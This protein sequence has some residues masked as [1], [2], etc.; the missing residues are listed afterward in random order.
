M[1]LEEKKQVEVLLM[2]YFRSI[3]P[4]FP[5]GK[6][7]PSESPDFIIDMKPRNSVGIEITR[8]YPSDQKSI[9]PPPEDSSFEMKFINKVKELVEGYSAQP[10]FVKFLFK[11]GHSINETQILSAAIMSAVS[12][13]KTLNNPKSDFSFKIISQ[14]QLPSFLKSVLVLR[15]RLLV[16]PIW[17]KANHQGLSNNIAADISNAILKKND[18][19]KLY[20]SK[21]LQQYWLLIT[22]DQLEAIRN[23]NNGNQI[24]HKKFSSLFHRVFLFELMKGRVIHLV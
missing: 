1:Q 10:L 12:I 11:K 8:L 20:Q 23:V 7:I 17:D 9:L 13:R 15:H 2:D 18:K 21:N 14:S 16:T 6:L 5:K 24:T 4:V 3:Y 19:L 22:T